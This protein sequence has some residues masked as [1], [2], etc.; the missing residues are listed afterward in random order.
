M[1]N[2]LI[3]GCQSF[4]VVVVFSMIGASEGGGRGIGTEGPG[5][6]AMAVSKSS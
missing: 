6:E 1:K 3:M 4:W 5:M 2:E